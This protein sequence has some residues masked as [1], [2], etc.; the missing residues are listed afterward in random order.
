MHSMPD[1]FVPLAPVAKSA[2]GNGNGFAPL[3]FRA[4][5]PAADGKA[6]NGATTPSRSP[7]NCAAPKVTLQRQGDMVTSIRVECP[8]GQVIELNCVY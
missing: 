1:T 3:E 8:C 6:P 7:Q 4:A 5:P 2:A